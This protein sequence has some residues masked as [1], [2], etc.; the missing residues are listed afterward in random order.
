MAPKDK[1]PIQK[2]VELY[3]DTNVTGWRVMKSILEKH[4][5]H[6]QTGSRNI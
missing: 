3:A 1:G 5:E 6:L 2:K 4:Q